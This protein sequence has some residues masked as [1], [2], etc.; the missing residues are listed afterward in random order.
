MSDGFGGWG[1]FRECGESFL[2]IRDKRN[3]TGQA[4]HLKKLDGLI[5]DIGED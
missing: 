5:V 2:F 4:E 1:K 3:M